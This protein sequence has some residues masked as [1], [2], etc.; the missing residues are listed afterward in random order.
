MMLS[1]G[2]TMAPHSGLSPVLRDKGLRTAGRLARRLGLKFLP[3]PYDI[4]RDGFY[5]IAG[6]P[7][8]AKKFV[9]YVHAYNSGKIEN[10]LGQ[11]FLSE[12]TWSIVWMPGRPRR[13]HE[14]GTL[15]HEVTHYVTNVFDRIGLPIDHDHDEAFAH[16]VGYGVRYV[17]EGLR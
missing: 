9:D 4:Y 1:G 13:G 11:T 8:A 15:A 2:S 3:V 7:D 17:L 5:F 14:Y 10:D 6:R 16:A 12:G